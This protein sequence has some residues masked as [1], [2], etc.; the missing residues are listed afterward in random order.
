VETHEFKRHPRAYFGRLEASAPMSA[1]VEDDDEVL[2]NSL[3]V[4]G[5]VLRKRKSP[6]R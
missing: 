3:R 1:P 6:D 2:G 5:K 4:G